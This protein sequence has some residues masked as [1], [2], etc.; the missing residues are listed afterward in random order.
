[1]LARRARQCRDT[2]RSCLENSSRANEGWLWGRHASFGL[3]AANTG[4]TLDNLDSLDYRLKNR[5]DLRNVISRLHLGLAE[6][7]A[8]VRAHV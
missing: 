5:P 6:H 1:M 4:A 3:W 2:F 7:S 8:K